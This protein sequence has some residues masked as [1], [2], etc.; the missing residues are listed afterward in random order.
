MIV[1]LQFVGLAL[2]YCL[3]GDVPRHGVQQFS[4]TSVARIQCMTAHVYN[5]AQTFAGVLV[6]TI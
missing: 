5:A 6:A 1:C 4:G 2:A 3:P